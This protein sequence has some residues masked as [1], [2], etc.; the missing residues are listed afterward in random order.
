MH[1]NHFS[2]LLSYCPCKSFLQSTV[3]EAALPT[4]FQFVSHEMFKE[5]VK[6]KFELPEG[7]QHQA[8]PITDKEKKA[9]R[10]VSGYVRRK[11]RKRIKYSSLAHKEEIILFICVG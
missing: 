2:N 10:H 9:L 7:V 11:V 3:G 4:F 8:S 5:L 1:V 6:A